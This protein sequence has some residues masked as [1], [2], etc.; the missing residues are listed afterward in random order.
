MKEKKQ[1]DAWLAAGGNWEA[2]AS[3]NQSLRATGRPTD[4]AF[5]FLEC[6]NLYI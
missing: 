3:R 5:L 2:Q 6:H 1:K 4:F